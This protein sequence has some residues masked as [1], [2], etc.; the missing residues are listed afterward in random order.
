MPHWKCLRVTEIQGTAAIGNK[1]L[2]QT[3]SG[4]SVKLY[5][6][7]LPKT[8]GAFLQSVRGQSDRVRTLRTALSVAEQQE[9][10]LSD[11]YFNNYV[12]DAVSVTA[13]SRGTVVDSEDARRARWKQAEANVKALSK[14]LV[15]AELD[16]QD[17]LLK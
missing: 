2:V 8:V 5:I 3:E 17:Q 10:K 14:S 1:C 6:S 13:T 16:Y 15:Q 9:A 12:G 11:I 4:T 7:N